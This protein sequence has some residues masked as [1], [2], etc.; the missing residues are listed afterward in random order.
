MSYG[1]WA[2]LNWKIAMFV[3]DCTWKKAYFTSISMG[4]RVT[5]DSL[6]YL[7]IN[8]LDIMLTCFRNVKNGPNQFLIFLR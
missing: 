4:G 8:R 6:V 2:L 5:M 1:F 3:L 7:S